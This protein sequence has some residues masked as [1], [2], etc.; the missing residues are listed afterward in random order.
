MF[1][2]TAEIHY[3][4]WFYPSSEAASVSYDAHF[5]FL[6]P[7]EVSHP[8]K[9]VFNVNEYTRAHPDKK[10]NNYSNSES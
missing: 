7:Q 3:C 9:K 8:C 2:T 1:Q 5:L 6:S 10:L 4:E